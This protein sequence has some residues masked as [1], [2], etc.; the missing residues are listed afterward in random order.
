VGVNA[1]I[2]LDTDLKIG[3][4]VLLVSALKSLSAWE[5]RLMCRMKYN[6]NSSTAFMWIGL[7]L[8]LL[9]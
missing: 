8:V 6:Y 9:W 4:L 1:N 7:L 5:N 2:S 3:V